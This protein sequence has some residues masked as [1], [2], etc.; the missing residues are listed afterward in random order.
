MLLWKIFQVG[1]A[2]NFHKARVHLVGVARRVA[3][4][5]REFSG[6]NGW[7]H[8]V[9][10]R[11]LTRQLWRVRREG[12][13]VP[14]YTCAK[15]WCFVQCL[16]SSNSEKAMYK[17]HRYVFRPAR[18]VPALLRRIWAWFWGRAWRATWASAWSASFW[19]LAAAG[20]CLSQ[21]AG[22][23]WVLIVCASR[24]RLFAASRKQRVYFRKWPHSGTWAFQ[25]HSHIGNRSILPLHTCL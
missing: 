16:K 9:W 17:P 19:D 12:W 5:T 6:Q 15:Y 10:G 13:E 24:F 22:S 8:Q 18:P 11:R 21:A 14:G 4:E 2:L 3:D 23:T 20:S 25:F 7:C 1:L